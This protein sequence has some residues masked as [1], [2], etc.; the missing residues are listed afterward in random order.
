MLRKLD[1]IKLD[2]ERG[3]VKQ[4]PN[5]ISPGH[6]TPAIKDLHSAILALLF[7]DTCQDFGQEMGTDRI[8]GGKVATFSLGKKFHPLL[9]NMLDDFLRDI[10]TKLNYV[11]NRDDLERL[12]AENEA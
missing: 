11:A 10:V 5:F 9:A 4:S 3:F 12:K 6:I 7:V 8:I 2:G 1:I